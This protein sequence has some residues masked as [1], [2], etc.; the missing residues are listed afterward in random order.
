M[1]I[2]KHALSLATALVLGASI[3]GL[4]A[5]PAAAEKKPKETIEQNCSLTGS[6]LVPPSENDY[7]FFV[8]GAL[9]VARKPNGDA[10]VLECQKDGTWKEV[11]SKAPV[12]QRPTGTGRVPVP[13]IE[14][15]P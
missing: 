12:Q 9:E 7:E 6:T 4:M 15:A 1:K 2:S 13:V 10:A 8:P 14:L 3:V 5:E 11:K